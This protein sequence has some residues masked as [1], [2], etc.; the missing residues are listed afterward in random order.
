MDAKILSSGLLSLETTGF[1]VKENAL[2][3]DLLEHMSIKI[4]SFA[5]EG[6]KQ[7][8]IGLK[9]GNKI[10]EDIRRDKIR[11][12]EKD[13]LDAIEKLFLAEMSAFM[14]S[15]SEHF[16][17][18]LNN[19]EFHYAV[20]G[21]EAFYKKHVDNF[22]GK[23]A[24]VFTVILYLNINWQKGDGGELVIFHD[25]D[26]TLETIVEPKMGTLVVFESA[27]FYHEVLPTHKD[28]LTI[29]GWFRKDKDVFSI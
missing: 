11:W 13:S 28:R 12:I 17:V 14:Q 29:T 2:P 16:Y 20:Y 9:A 5:N 1:W 10:N 8:G 24:R 19:Y 6:F 27:R 26:S 21:E 4:Q 18:G 25:D 22:K 23:N 3:M 7:A 15:L